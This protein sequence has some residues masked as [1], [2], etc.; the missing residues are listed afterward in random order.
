MRKF[1]LI[2]LFLSIYFLGHSQ[3]KGECGVLEDTMQ[4]IRMKI[5]QKNRRTLFMEGVARKVDISQFKI[6][7]LNTFI[8]SVYQQAF[9]SP[10]FPEYI[11]AGIRHCLG[12]SIARRFNRDS[13]ELFKDR[14]YLIDKESRIRIIK[15]SDGI[16]ISFKQITVAGKFLQV[17]KNSGIYDNIQ[18]QIPNTQIPSIVEYLIPVSMQIVRTNAKK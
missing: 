15:L 8:S 9:F 12:D 5:F 10:Q 14:S 7:D 6:N 17:N 4:Y 11:N 13:L 16:V 3:S 1:M 18:D 2:P